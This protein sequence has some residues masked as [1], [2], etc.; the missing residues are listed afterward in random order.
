M[1]VLFNQIDKKEITIPTE[2]WTDSIYRQLQDEDMKKDAQ[3]L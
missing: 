3:T 1:K 2:K